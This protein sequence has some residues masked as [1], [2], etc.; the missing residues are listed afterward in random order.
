MQKGRD[1]WRG[2]H[3]E[4]EQLEQSLDWLLGAATLQQ[5]IEEGDVEVP[6]E[7]FN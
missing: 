4:A 5:L 3:Y 1:V 6:D 7:Q 2:V